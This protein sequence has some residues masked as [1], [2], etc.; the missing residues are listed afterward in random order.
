MISYDRQKRPNLLLWGGALV[1][2][3]AVGAGLWWHQQQQGPDAASGVAAVSPVEPPAS[4][5]EALR[6]LSTPPAVLDDGRPADF[7]PDEWKSLQDTVGKSPNGAQELAR[8]A[9]YL[10]FQRAFTQWQELSENGTPE[11]RRP[12][13]EKL[14][15]TVPE[16]LKQSE[17]TIGEA[18]MLA[19]VL[20]ND[21]EPDESARAAKLDAYRIQLEAV[22]PK[23]DQAAEMR[24]ANCLAEYK[25]REAVIQ[26]EYLSQPEGQRD[27]KKFE[28]D[29]D[30]AHKA[31]YEA[32][33]CA[34][35]R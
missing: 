30:A 26:Q 5:A 31:V 23:V 12:L 24:E 6:N 3:A 22:A 28:T 14:L 2:G 19:A 25:R 13:A 21:I 7:S 17:V 27:H 4:A 16:R 18:L 35:R 33:D 29:L 32:T 15:Q 8:V 11:Q 9:N 34:G 20:Y 1:L 10:R